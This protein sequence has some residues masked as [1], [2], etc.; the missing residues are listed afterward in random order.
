[1]NRPYAPRQPRS[2]R[3][4]TAG[5]TTGGTTTSGIASLVTFAT[6]GIVGLSTGALAL[7]GT[8]LAS[9]QAPGGTA[10]S[11]AGAAATPAASPTGSVRFLVK[12]DWGTGSSAQAAVTKGMCASHA[13]TPASF[14]LTTGDNFY[15]PDGTA[16]RAS[17]DRPEACLLA[18]GLPWRATW[19]NH[20]LGGNSTATRLASPKRWYSFTQGPVRVI[21]LDGN[22][23]SSS[24]QVAFLRRTLER[25]K[26]P[27]RIVTIHQPPY[28]AGLH[29]PSTT[30][31]RLMVPLFKKHGVSLVL[32]GHNHSYERIVTGGVTYIVSGGGGAQVYPCVRLPAG[33][34]K[35]T[36]EY[37]FLEVDASPAS[38]N[39][40]AVRRDGSTLESVSVPVRT[41]APR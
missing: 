12:G 39:V 29:E 28:T 8:A 10:A 4:A 6:L 40:R 15:S 20:D 38:I 33:L 1:M 11:P 2:R 17:F 19:G 22:Q 5:T 30:Q 32:S 36:P 9:S 18:T 34:K 21:V 26:E 35:C 31:Q 25:A 13:A 27:V 14:I 41:P 16:T 3:D 37:H 24:A 7:G 23:P